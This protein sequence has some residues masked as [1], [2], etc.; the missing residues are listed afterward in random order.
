MPIITVDMFAGRTVE[1]RAEIAK[2]LTTAFVEATGAKP[3]SVHVI[4]RDVAKSDWC[5]GGEMCSDLYPEPSAGTAK[6]N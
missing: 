5:V 6:Q 1:K 4:L 2:A 3:Q